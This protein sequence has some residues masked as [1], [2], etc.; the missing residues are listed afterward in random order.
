M[1]PW[2]PWPPKLAAVFLDILRDLRDQAADEP[3]P[4]RAGVAPYTQPGMAGQTFVLV[5]GGMLS[6]EGEIVGGVRE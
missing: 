6:V 3:P 5:E 4:C 1:L 2:E